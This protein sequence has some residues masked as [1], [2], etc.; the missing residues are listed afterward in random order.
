VTTLLRA[1]VAEAVAGTT[2]DA[3]HDASHK[4]EAREQRAVLKVQHG[5]PP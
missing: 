4:N 1:G 2:D 5:I 3:Q